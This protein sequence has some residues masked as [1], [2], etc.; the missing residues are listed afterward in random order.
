MYKLQPN[1]IK[2][3]ALK[4]Q[5]F[6]IKVLKLRGNYQYP[7]ILNPSKTKCS[8]I[9]MCDCIQIPNVPL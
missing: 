6:N 9:F 7:M 5:G 1:F 3:F 8:D 4:P 2:I